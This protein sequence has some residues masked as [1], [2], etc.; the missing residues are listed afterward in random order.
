MK[1]G[2]GFPSAYARQSGGSRPKAKYWSAGSSSAWSASSGTL[3]SL[4]PKTFDTDVAITPVPWALTAYLAFTGVR[5]FLGYRNALTRWFLTL[6]VIVDM[7]LL[8][9]LI[10]SFHIQYEQPTAFVLKAPTLLYVF[11]FIA[12]RA[13]RFDAF[14][15]LL[16]GSTAA[17][18]W[19]F[20]V[21]MS[22]AEESTGSRAI[23]CFT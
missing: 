10:W 15:V 9:G 11:I 7:A 19:L 6:S 2:S 23:S 13:L 8:M 16:A 4:S 22:V 12:L 14:F 1:Q 18:G 3:Y 5:L 17:V 20:M 21:G